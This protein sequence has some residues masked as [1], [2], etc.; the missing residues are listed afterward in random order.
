MAT[1][2]ESRAVY[3]GLA[4]CAAVLLATAAVAQ[5]PLHARISY[6]GSGMIKGTDD[7]DWSYATLN[8]LVMPNDTLWVDKEGTLELEMSGGSFLRMADGTKAV[9]VSLPPTGYIRGQVGSFYVQRVNRSSGDIQ[10]ETPVSK[11]IVDRD[12]QVRFDVLDSGATTVTVRWGSATVR[13]EGGGD[14]VVAQ[15]QRTYIDPGYLPSEPAPFDLSAEDDFDSWNRERGRLLAVGSEAVPPAVV[16]SSPPVGLADLSPYG[17]WVTI[18]NGY[19]WR[20]TTVVDFVPYRA[21]HWSFVPGCGYVWVDDYPFG[22]VTCHYGR[23]WH[24]NTYGWVWGYRDTWSPAW[25]ASVRYGPNFVWCPLDPWDSPYV[26]TTDYFVVGGL[27]FGIYASTYCGADDLLIGHY[28]AHPCTPTIFHGVPA[29]QINVWNINIGGGGHYRPVHYTDSR[30]EYRDYSPRR[31]IR[32]P[33]IYGSG[34]HEARAR[35]ATL[36]REFPAMRDKPRTISTLSPSGRT[37]VDR[38]AHAPRMRNVRVA[39]H[40][41]S[42]VRD[43]N[44]RMSSGG[45]A[46]EL[47]APS[48][49]MRRSESGR[50][51]TKTIDRTRLESTP[52]P[53]PMRTRG[54]KT[55]S[56]PPTISAPTHGTHST[57]PSRSIAPAPTRRGRATV[58]SSPAPKFQAPVTAPTHRTRT[59]SI[60]RAPDPAPQVNVAPRSRDVVQSAPKF[61]P[62]TRSTRSAPEIV[63]AEPPTPMRVRHSAPDVQ[64]APKIQAPQQAEPRHMRSRG[65]QDDT[66]RNSSRGRSIR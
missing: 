35:V 57:P 44:N 40:A 21:G 53:A 11:T 36:E 59:R 25:V 9:I 66:R 62:R 8:T 39:P 41:L 15:G 28:Y 37:V 31:V 64:S 56:E 65:A 43:L 34:K 4:L 18:D 38:S 33:E 54:V 19:W 3:A 22:Y 49:T 27:H 2:I 61:E 30:L 60:S 24:N 6:A 1:K 23:W 45:R 55:E 32:G 51:V 12:S 20:P 26:S 10:F 50:T 29:T 63:K 52:K 17:E 42:S 46:P 13:A 16:M 7:A 5:E 14:V 47:S 48:Q 58:D